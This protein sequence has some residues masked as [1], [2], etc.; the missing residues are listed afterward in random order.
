MEAM[1]YK[2][3]IGNLAFIE[4]IA[5]DSPDV[6]NAYKNNHVQTFPP[7]FR[8]GQ[9]SCG[10]P[11]C[12]NTLIP[13][14]VAT[15]LSYLNLW[16]LVV[17]EG[18]QSVLIVEDDIEL[19]SNA[20]ALAKSLNDDDLIS[21]S[22]LMLDA[23]HLVRLGWA[24]SEDH[25]S[26]ERP[27]FEKV[28][29]MSNPAHAVNGAMAQLLLDRFESIDTTVDI[30]QHRV[31][32]N[33]QNSETLFPPMFYELSWST[34][35]IESLIHPKQTRVQFLK[36]SGASPDEIERAEQRIA[37]HEKHTSVYDILGVG[38]PRCG[39][40]YT[41]S[42]LE[43]LGL[44]VGH[45]K[46][47]GNGIVSWMFAVD[48]DAPWALNDGAR[49][50]RFKHF[51]NIVRFVRNPVDSVPSIIRDDLRSSE[52]KEFRRDCILEALGIDVDSYPTALERAV[53]SL[54]YWDDLVSEM[55]PK[56]TF[57]VEDEEA[58]LIDFVCEKVESAGRP[59]DQSLYP[60]KNV[61]K[62]KLYK[63]QSYSKPAVSLS[64]FSEI[65]SML[66]VKLNAYCRRY[67]Y[68]TF[69]GEEYSGGGCM[70][71]DLDLAN[72]TKLTLDPI[73]WSRS[74]REQVPVDSDGEPLPWW[75]YPA[76]EFVEQAVRAEDRVFEYGAGNSTMWWASRVTQVIAVDHDQKW[77]EGV[78]SKLRNPHKVIL[79]ERSDDP[80]SS[81]ELLNN[82]LRRNPRTHF[83][84]DSDKVIRRGLDDQRFMDY[85]NTINEVGGRF[86]WIVIDGMCRRLCAY[87]AV[88]RLSENGVIIFDNS[89][90]S[91][92][93]EGY[94]YLIESGF[95]QIRFSGIVPGADFPSC[96]SIFIKSLS[97]L[98]RV[99][100]SRSMF[101]IKEY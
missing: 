15:F 69:K 61:N 21:S 62:D 75:T 1:V 70:L 86:D 76:I 73:G 89:N 5:S 47:L 90:R 11:G 98:P 92:Y 49:S 53:A 83:D 66:L 22:K 85:A 65:D 24:L 78:Q 8:C 30:Y 46:L 59:K 68:E 60:K 32:A 72:F 26:L 64:D 55:N 42:L 34:G 88:Q 9:L 16:R 29:K 25:H 39:S 74:K 101:G 44:E 6:D 51:K 94:Q 2:Y 84:Y 17:K 28:S 35:E 50:R 93:F 80:R 87:Y 100:F 38:H 43:A 12:N 57:R 79:S 81:K 82:Y 67:G 40:G 96:T 36:E 7:C 10:S 95:Y 56:L 77:V 20:E 18:Y 58:K 37:T 54:V 41:A 45:E 27:R 63:G 3:Q 14:Q 71:H 23:P 13:A 97:A 31:V 19:V 33:D 48:R 52:S 99:T 4:A 91:D